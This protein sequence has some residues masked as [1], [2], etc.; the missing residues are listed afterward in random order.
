MA[1]YKKQLPDITPIDKP[2]WEAAKRH[3]LVAYRCL[4]CGTFYSQVTECV[5]CDKPRMEWVRVSGKGE[6]YTFGIYHQLYHPAWKEEIPYN[7]SWIKLNEGPLLM[8]NIVECKNEDLY[9]G[10]PVEVVFEDVTEEVTLPKFKP[11]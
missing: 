3:E 8:S 2:F 9:I 7:V 4:N 5:A 6:V 11:V 10:M 1:E